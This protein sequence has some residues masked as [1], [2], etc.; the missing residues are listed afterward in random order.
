LL[1]ISPELSGADQ[2][3]GVNG[4]GSSVRTN[5][6]GGGF[7]KS[8]AFRPSGRVLVFFIEVLFSIPFPGGY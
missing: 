1:I 8:F 2:I 6:A 4:F 3:A 5:G 7:A